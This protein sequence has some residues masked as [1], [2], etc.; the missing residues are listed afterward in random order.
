[1]KNLLLTLCLLGKLGA[2]ALPVVP[3]QT[4]PDQ[5]ARSLRDGNVSMPAADCK[6][7][8]LWEC[9]PDEPLRA[10]D[11]TVRWVQLDDDPELE[12]VLVTEAKAE[13]TYAAYAFDKQ[14]T[15]NLVGSFFCKRWC[16]VNSLIRVQKLTDDSPP[17]LLCYRDRGGSGIVTLT[18]EAFQLRAGKLWPAFEVTNYENVRYMSPYTKW[19]RVLASPNRIVIHTIREAPPGQASRNECEVWRWDATNHSFVPVAGEQ[20]K[21]CDPKTGV[22]IAGKSFWTGLPVHP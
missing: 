11:V 15:W 9:H 5:L 20:I 18:T 4:A 3:I 16:D 6:A 22:P 13:N 17:L 12:V 19:Q 14:S 8:D 21:Y 7:L 10:K 1:M 2:Q